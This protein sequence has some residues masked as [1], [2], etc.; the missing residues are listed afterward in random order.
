MGKKADYVISLKGNQGNLHEAVK[1]YWEA[2]DFNKPAAQA[3]CIKFRSVS[4]YDEKHG[5]K[6]T[7][8][9]AVSD[10]VRWLWEMFPQWKSINSIG[11]VE[12][13][14]EIGGG[15]AKNGTAVF[16]FQPWRR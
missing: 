9:Y 16:C 5:R 4:T 12:S 13:T 1:E 8:D 3:N 7:R 2:L 10:D 11:V 14:R 6:E 15:E